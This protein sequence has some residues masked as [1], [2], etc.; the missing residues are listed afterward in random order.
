MTQHRSQNRASRHLVDLDA[1]YRERLH[2]GH[3][4]APAETVPADGTLLDVVPLPDT[5]K[6]LM[7]VAHVVP[8]SA[9]LPGAFPAVPADTRPACSPAPPQ[10]TVGAPAG[11]TS[12]DD[13]PADGAH[14]PGESQTL[15]TDDAS[16]SAEGH[17]PVPP[18]ADETRRDTAPLTVAGGSPLPASAVRARPSSG[19][20][21]ET[22]PDPTGQASPPSDSPGRKGP[23]ADPGGA[24][25]VRDDDAP[26]QALRIDQRSRRVWVGGREIGL[27]YQEFE[28]LVHFT[29]HPWQVFSRA[30]LMQALWP[31]ADA[32]TRTVDVHVHRLRRKLGSAGSQLATV[33]RVGYTYRPHLVNRSGLAQA[34]E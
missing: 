23:W 3:A 34:G 21:K 14:V 26:P 31:A 13:A 5:G 4:L 10:T 12:T 30:E 7:I 33:R 28:L 9:A 16:T 32:A 22:S 1:R 18:M 11:A 2:R 24:E 15:L 25:P 27:T 6:V 19:P 20:A 17:V 29:K 8:A